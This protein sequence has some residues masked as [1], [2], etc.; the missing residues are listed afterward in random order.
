MDAFLRRVV[1]QREV[2]QEETI[3]KLKPATLTRWCRV[4]GERVRLF[5]DGAG[6]HSFPVAVCSRC[7]GTSRAKV[8][9]RADERAAAQA[10]HLVAPQETMT[11]ETKTCLHCGKKLRRSN[12][13]GVCPACISKTLAAEDGGK[14]ALDAAA[15]R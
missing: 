14:T 12:T 4:C 6:H 8:L 15:R 2:E 3:L 9:H 7:G 13:R 10:R 11:A 1:A 5:D